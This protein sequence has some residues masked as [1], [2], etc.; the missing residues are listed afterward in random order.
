LSTTHIASYPA[1]PPPPPL[2]A[3]THENKAE[4]VARVMKVLSTRVR[5]KAAVRPIFRG[6]DE[7]CPPQQTQHDRAR[8]V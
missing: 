8:R 3:F 2:R 5:A 4:V 6:M 1:Y 7:V